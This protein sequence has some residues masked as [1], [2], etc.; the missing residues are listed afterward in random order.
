MGYCLFPN[1]SF[2]FFWITLFV[3]SFVC[4]CVSLL[5]TF[6]FPGNYTSTG[7]PFQD[8]DL[9]LFMILLPRPWNPTLDQN[10]EDAADIWCST[11][12]KVTDLE[13]L[14]FTYFIWSLTFCLIWYWRMLH[15]LKSLS[16]AKLKLLNQNYLSKYGCK[17]STILNCILGWYN[18]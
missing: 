15:I 16:T 18:M 3:L 12:L 2:T 8:C 13:S 6:L 10:C 17:S 9:D 11:T 14:I 1:L 5:L 7:F 4:V